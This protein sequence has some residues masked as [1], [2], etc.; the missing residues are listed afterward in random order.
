M[1]AKQPTSA[2]HLWDLLQLIERS[3]EYLISIVERTTQVCSALIVKSLE[4]L[5]SSRYFVLFINLEIAKIIFKKSTIYTPRD[6]RHQDRTKEWLNRFIIV[7]MFH[8]SGAGA[9]RDPASARACSW[10]LPAALSPKN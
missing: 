2:T 1:K 8:L 3:K 6:K 10:H 5:A 4:T 9:S 7:L